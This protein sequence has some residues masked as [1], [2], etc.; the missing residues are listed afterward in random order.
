MIAGPLPRVVEVVAQAR[1]GVD[2]RRAA[3]EDHVRRFRV[4]DHARRGATG[5]LG[6]EE[7]RRCEKRGA[8][9]KMFDSVSREN[10]HP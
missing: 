9:K 2:F 7:G 1:A 10:A 5:R 4:P 8:D 3:E 6:S